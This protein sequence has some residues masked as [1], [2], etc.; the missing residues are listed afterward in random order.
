MPQCHTNIE[1]LLLLLFSF[2]LST[3]GLQGTQVGCAR[4]PIHGK[5]R[6]SEK[7]ESGLKCH[8][9]PTVLGQKCNKLQDSKE[10]VH[11]NQK[12]K[13]RREHEPSQRPGRNRAE[14]KRDGKQR[15]MGDF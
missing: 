6:R 12:K 7:A 2:V 11:L 4:Y 10:K 5:I 15:E 3:F 1:V 14:I 13:K 8:G 9:T